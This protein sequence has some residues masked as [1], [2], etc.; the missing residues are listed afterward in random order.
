MDVSARTALVWSERYRLHD[1]GAHP[2]APE[3]ITALERA[4]RAAGLFD[5]RLVLA[6]LPAT[7]EQIEAV[8]APELVALV[9]QVAE[10]GG[11]GLDP[12]TY[13]SPASYEIAL[14]AAGGA[15]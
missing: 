8:H 7:V 11:G 15:C 12:D 13:V 1:T 2:E 3:R 5:D 9:R 4:L 10:A 14:L 6:P